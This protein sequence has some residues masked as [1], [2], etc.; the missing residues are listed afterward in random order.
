MHLLRRIQKG[1]PVRRDAPRLAKHPARTRNAGRAGGLGKGLG[2]LQQGRAPAGANRGPA[3]T[4][5]D[6][7]ARVVAHE[8]QA[9]GHRQPMRQRPSLGPEAPGLPVQEEELCGPRAQQARIQP[10]RITLIGRVQTLETQR[11]VAGVEGVV[12][13]PGSLPGVADEP[14]LGLSVPAGEFVEAFLQNGSVRLPIAGELQDVAGTGPAPLRTLERGNQRRGLDL[15][16]RQPVGQ[17]PAVG[18]ELRL[19]GD[20]VLAVRHV[21]PARV[22]GEVGVLVDVGDEVPGLAVVEAD[23]AAG[24]F[25]EVHRVL[26]PFV[27]VE[28]VL[29]GLRHVAGDA[30]RTRRPDERHALGPPRHGE[31]IGPLQEVEQ[32]HLQ[33]PVEQGRTRDVAL[34]PAGRPQRFVHLDVDEIGPGHGVDQHPL[35]GSKLGTVLERFAQDGVEAFVEVALVG[36]DRG[37]E[38]AP[39]EVRQPHRH[40]QRRAGARPP[41]L[42]PAVE[43]APRIDVVGPRRDGEG[44]RVRRIGDRVK[45]GLQP[46]RDLRNGAGLEELEH[47]DVDGDAVEGFQ[48]Q[49]DVAGGRH[50]RRVVDA[51]V[52]HP[53]EVPLRKPRLEEHVAG[54]HLVTD[55]RAVRVLALPD[56]HLVVAHDVHRRPVFSRMAGQKMNHGLRA[57]I[58]GGEVEGDAGPVQ[59]PQGLVD[60]E[61]S[62]GV[63]HEGR[64]AGRL[65][66][67]A[68]ETLR[69]GGLQRAVRRDLQ[70]HARLEV[71]PDGLHRRREPHC[72]ADVRPPV[73]GVQSLG[74]LAGHRGHE[75]D[76]GV[77]VA[78]VQERQGRQRIVPERV[79]GGGVKGDVAGQQTILPVAPIQR[80]H[81]GPQRRLPAADDGAGRGV[82]AG[83][84]DARRQV[85][86][87]TEG[88]LQGL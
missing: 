71:A 22:G 76:G 17:R 37:C 69:D 10:R 68:F 29:G 57:R 25:A 23:A 24:A 3:G 11:R 47:L 1:H 53:R 84:L 31:Q 6:D 26:A 9:A 18:D 21:V 28:P 80:L 50:D 45:G 81:D 55:Q 79:H 35:D 13:F 30:R 44:E 60:A 64:D 8:R 42:S 73:V 63:P 74:P 46:R 59:R 54:G 40:V 62:V 19:P 58:L 85:F 65:G 41:D 72:T 14:V 32:E 78:V 27:H 38:P 61:A 7:F 86:P 67:A 12:V 77:E 48:D 82:L 20:H 49:L 34:L 83:D 56:E 51:V 4:G 88:N 70:H 15:P 36:D 2:R 33:P 52:H 43:L 5:L 16:V 75:R 39:V 87:G 66:G